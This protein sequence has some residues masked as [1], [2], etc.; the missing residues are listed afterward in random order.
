MKKLE[1]KWSTLLN[2]GAFEIVDRPLDVQVIHSH[3][4]HTIKTHADGSFELIKARLVAN[5]KEQE[6]GVNYTETYAPTPTPDLIRLLLIIAAHKNWAVGQ[7]DVK[8]AYVHA[9]YWTKH[10]R[11]NPRGVNIPKRTRCWNWRKPF[12]DWNK[13]DMNGIII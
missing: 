7:A 11:R 6:E 8:T 2:L 5:G 9:D 1:K 12:M 13:P 10:L 4:V 3:F